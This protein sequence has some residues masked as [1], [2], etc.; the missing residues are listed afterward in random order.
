MKKVLLTI[1][2]FLIIG[3]CAGFI[4]L[5]AMTLGE[6]DS[7]FNA[8]YRYLLAH[9]SWAREL[10]GLQFDGDARADYLGEKFPSIFIEVDAMDGVGINNEILQNFIQK[11]EAISGKPVIFYIS[12]KNIVYQGAVNLKQVDEVVRRYRDYKK[13]SEAALIYLLF[14]SGSAAQPGQI[15]ATYQEDGIII[16]KETL[17]ELSGGKKEELAE[18]E[19]ATLLHEFGH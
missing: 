7:Y 5:K 13:S 11:I 19:L 18:Q 3:L 10:F 12:D 16:Y 2:L 17:R 14:A 9:H 6:G 1:F 15:G 8:N 4:F